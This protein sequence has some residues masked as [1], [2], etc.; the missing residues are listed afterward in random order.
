MGDLF[1]ALYVRRSSL[2]SATDKPFASNS[3]TV[4]AQSHNRLTNSSACIAGSSPEMEVNMI[5]TVNRLR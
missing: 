3:S 4:G 1:R 5:R 2:A